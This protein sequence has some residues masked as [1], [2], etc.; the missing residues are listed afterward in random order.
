MGKPVEVRVLSRA[1][2]DVSDDVE[3]A[4]PLRGG[5]LNSVGRRAFT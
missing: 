2:V 4:I 5:E 1:V 3:L